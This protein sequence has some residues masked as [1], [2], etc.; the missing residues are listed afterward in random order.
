MKT[1]IISVETSDRLAAVW[2]SKRDSFNQSIFFYFPEN[3]LF[4]ENKKQNEEY[5]SANFLFTF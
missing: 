4:K 3:F 1:E 2:T 5:P